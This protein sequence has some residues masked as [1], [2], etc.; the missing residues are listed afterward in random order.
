MIIDGSGGL[1]LR[2]RN[3]EF[4]LTADLQSPID[5]DFL[6]RIRPYPAIA[7]IRNHV[8]PLNLFIFSHISR[9]SVGRVLAPDFVVDRNAQLLRNAFITSSLPYMVIT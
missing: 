1:I 3:N 5:L 7:A 8:L 6:C 2:Q 4:L 9:P